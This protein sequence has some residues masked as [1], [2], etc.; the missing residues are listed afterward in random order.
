[1]TQI[2]EHITLEELTKSQTGDRLGLDNIPPPAELA[3]LKAVCE[4]VV[5]KV[6]AHFVITTV[7]IK[8]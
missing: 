4:H 8:K 7:V 6:R 1:M 5:E 2:T 3:A